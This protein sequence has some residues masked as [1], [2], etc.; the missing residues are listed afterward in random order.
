MPVGTG[1]GFGGALVHRQR[2]R[3][4]EQHQPCQCLGL[5]QG[6]P[7][8]HARAAVVGAD[9]KARVA[10]VAHHRQRIG[11]H[12]PLAVQRVVGRGRQACAVA[13]ATQVHRHHR[14]SL[15]QRAGHGVPHGVR[16]RVA[17]QQQ[18]RRPRAADA[19]TQAHAVV[20]DVV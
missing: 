19:R 12:R 9:G 4:V 14:E 8:R 13:T 15:G 20:V 7:V 11:G 1:E 2:W 18:Q 16:L 17:M 3:D 10:E 6:Q 5:V